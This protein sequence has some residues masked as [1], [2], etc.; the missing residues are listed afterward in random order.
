MGRSGD[1]K[2]SIKLRW[3]HVVDW[4]SSDMGG[5]PQKKDGSGCLLKFL[6]RTPKR[7]EDYT[8]W[9]WLEFFSIPKR[10]Q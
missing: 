9:A 7:Y 1:G 10:L 3:P 8:L 2:Q 4:L 6:K 5:L